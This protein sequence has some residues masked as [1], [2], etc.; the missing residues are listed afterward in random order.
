MTEPKIRC[1]YYKRQKRECTYKDHNLGGCAGLATC[2]FHN[3]QIKCP[4]WRD[5]LAKN[6]LDKDLHRLKENIA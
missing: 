5:F 1:V 2:R 4:I 3:N 6:K